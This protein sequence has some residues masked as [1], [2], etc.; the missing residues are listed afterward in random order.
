MTKPPTQLPPPEFAWFPFRAWRVNPPFLESR[1]ALPHDPWAKRDTWR[2]HPFFSKQNRIRSMAPGLGLGTAAF[3]LYYVYDKWYQTQ[4]PGK[5]E[6]EKWAKFM[7]EREARLA[8]SG[9]GHGHH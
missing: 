3:A 7:E 4:G 9:H 8:A 5:A 1:R 6:H 2:Y